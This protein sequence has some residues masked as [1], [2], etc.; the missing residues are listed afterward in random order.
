MNSLKSTKNSKQRFLLLLNYLIYVSLKIKAYFSKFNN[1]LQTGIKLEVFGKYFGLRNKNR[2]R[3]I[4]LKLLE[5]FRTCLPHY[6]DYMKTKKEFFRIKIEDSFYNKFKI[7]FHKIKSYQEEL[8]NFILFY[9]ITNCLLIRCLLS[10]VDAQ[11][12]NNIRTAYCINA[13]TN[14]ELLQF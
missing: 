1:F 13:R 6:F 14:E 11:F 8:L 4:D 3:K 9:R 5:H 7:S 2:I 10:I 12:A